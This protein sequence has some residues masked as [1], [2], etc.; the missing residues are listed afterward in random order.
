[1]KWFNI[2]LHIS[3]IADM[4]RIFQSLGHQVDDRCLSGHHWVMKRPPDRVAELSDEK[5]VGIVRGWKFDTFYHNHKELNEY[6][7]FIVTYPPV[8]A[9]LYEKYDKPIIINCP[10]R[11]DYSLHDSPEM[12]SKWNE[13]LV[14]HVKSGQVILVANNKYDR[15]YLRIQTGLEATHIP[16]LCQYFPPKPDGTGKDFLMYEK[17]AS[18]S[19]WAPDI[20]DHWQGLQRPWKWEDLHRYKAVWHHPYQVS[21]MSIFEHYT[22]N[23]PMV[24]PTPRLLFELYFGGWAVVLTQVSTFQYSGVKHTKSIVPIRGDLDPNDWKSRDTVEKLWIPNA[25]YYDAEWMPHIVFYDNLNDELKRVREETDFALVHEN[26]KRDAA[27]REKAVYD[28]WESILK[29]VCHDCA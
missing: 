29:G 27:A 19:K 6:D 15:E 14:E 18:L 25:D 20:L 9:M 4:K 8:F 17:G 3:V 10:I 28:K 2:D 24:F 1:M 23:I 7:G 26:M 22:A 5:W 13:W 12:L 11:Y 21:T 16:S